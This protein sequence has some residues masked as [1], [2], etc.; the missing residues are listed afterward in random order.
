ML[1]ICSGYF[2]T[3]LSIFGVRVHFANPRELS[4][5]IRRIKPTYASMDSRE[6]ALQSFWH[7]F[8]GI[9]WSKAKLRTLA[10]IIGNLWTVFKV[11]VSFSI[12]SFI[13]H[14]AVSWSGV[15]WRITIAGALFSFNV[16]FWWSSFISSWDSTNTPSCYGQ[17]YFF[18]KRS[19]K[20]ATITTFFKVSSIIL[21]VPVAFLASVLYNIVLAMVYFTRDFLYRHMVVHLVELA[22][23]DAWN[24][25][26]D[27]KKLAFGF[28]A[29]LFVLPGLSPLSHMLK[30]MLEPVTSNKFRTVQ[31]RGHTLT[32]RSRFWIRSESRH[33]GGITEIR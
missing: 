15:A 19:L 23:P 13:K 21:L 25:F 1:L 31:Q 7:E 8:A 33:R 17:V 5:F 28:S 22:N 11:K 6:A 12:A 24:K 3:I 9:T 4:R 32:A 20:D 14:S 29:A 16:W 18:G 2:F 10:A 26:S 27:K 30:V